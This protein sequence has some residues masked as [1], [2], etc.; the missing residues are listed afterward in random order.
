M[1][2]NELKSK[3]EELKS[4]EQL[5]EEAQQEADAI[6]DA[7]KEEMKL[8]DVEEMNVDIFK[9]KWKKVISNRIDTTAL[10]KDLPDV[11]SRYTVPTE[12]RR[13]AITV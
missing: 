5:I 11:A 3:I 10:K 2:Q 7:I 4:L 9:I 8:S 12:S 13:F 1:S 6:K